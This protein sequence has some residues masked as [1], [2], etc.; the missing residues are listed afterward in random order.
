MRFTVSLLLTYKDVKC[1]EKELQRTFLK[2]TTCLLL[3][4][5]CLLFSSYGNIGF[6]QFVSMLRP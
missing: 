1:K 4:F 5:L 6:N 3:L 2:V